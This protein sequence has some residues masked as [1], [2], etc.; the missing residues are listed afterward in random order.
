MGN[1][2]AKPGYQNQFTLKLE[3]AADFGVSLT[4][5]AVMGDSGWTV[6]PLAFT[7]HEF[8]PG[9]TVLLDLMVDVPPGL[10]QGGMYPLQVT[11]DID[12]VPTDIGT[13]TVS[14][15]LPLTVK[16]NDIIDLVPAKADAI[17][18]LEIQSFDPSPLTVDY[19]VTDSN[20]LSVTVDG[21]PVIDPMGIT[22]VIIHV[23]VPE[24]ETLVGVTGDVTLTITEPATGMEMTEL[25]EYGI[26]EPLEILGTGGP[27][28]P[29][30]TGGPP[31]QEFPWEFTLRNHCD[32]E[33]A[34]NIVLTSDVTSS[35]PIPFSVPPG[36][37]VP[38]QA[39]IT[40]PEDHVPCAQPVELD[41]TTS[42]NIGS[43]H[44]DLELVI[45]T[46]VTADIIRRGWS[47]NAGD[48]VTVEAEVRNLRSDQPMAIDFTWFDNRNW[49]LTPPTGSL[50]LAPMESDTLEAQFHLVPLN[51][52]FA[53]SDSVSVAV[54]MTYDSGQP[55]T[56]GSET[57]IMVNYTA[58][59]VV[60]LPG[61]PGTR[62]DAN[63]PNP[64][65]PMTRIRFNLAETGPVKLTVHDLAG[66]LVAVI[67]DGRLDQGYHE[68]FWDGRA[69]DGSE[70]ASGVYFIRL[71]TRSG[72]WTKKAMLIR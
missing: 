11:G 47:G 53:D 52:A 68:R 13:L 6:Q 59:D 9:E 46:P 45:N 39:V 71:E 21:N 20:G 24:D 51:K 32:I 62:L 16:I 27:S 64:F 61:P 15:G 50:V 56:T 63:Y 28:T 72:V 22:P 17:I 49:I 31:D 57:W 33:L 41:A 19:M 35:T 12:G 65:N 66:R 48:I 5:L 3:D 26:E 43:R 36:G 38:V 29:V 14:I 2:R 44:L 70:A 54:S 60:D 58:S 8:T 34:G 18:D 55:A 37:E 10:P 67:H 1:G 25:V 7:A 4:N 23:T 40:I 69:A 30:Y 42:P